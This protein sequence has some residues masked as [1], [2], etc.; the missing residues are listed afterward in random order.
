[1]TYSAKVDFR[2]LKYHNPDLPLNFELY[3]LNE[4]KELQNSNR[5]CS[6]PMFTATTL[7]GSN[8]KI[9]NNARQDRKAIKRHSNYPL[10]VYFNVDLRTSISRVYYVHQMD[11]PTKQIHCNLKDTK[12]DG[13]I[14]FEG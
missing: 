12:F 4:E 1:V 6:K 8:F 10:L 5:T 13:K 14:Q 7:S 3:L 2:P 11:T 9:V